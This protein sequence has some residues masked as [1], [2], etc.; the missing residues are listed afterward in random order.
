M[1][2]L[3][4]DA[5]SQRWLDYAPVT[6]SRSIF[7]GLKRGVGALGRGIALYVDVPRFE[8]TLSRS[9]KITSRQSGPYWYAV[10]VGPNRTTRMPLED[11]GPGTR[12]KLYLYASAKY[13]PGAKPHAVSY[14]SRS[15][16]VSPARMKLRRWVREFKDRDVPLTRGEYNRLHDAGKIDYPPYLWVNP[17]HTA[18]DFYEKPLAHLNELMK[19]FFLPAFDGAV[20][21]EGIGGTN[22]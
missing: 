5:D 17:Q 7:N 15:G 13:A 1:F 11:L 14:W 19:D 22:G 3:R 9:F 2:D 18:G 8:E 16:S 21:R 6:V 4:L 20:R 10:R 12:G